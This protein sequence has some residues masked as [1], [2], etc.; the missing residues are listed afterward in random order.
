[1]FAKSLVKSSAWNLIGQGAPILFALIT[2]PLLLKTIGEARY[3]FLTV[4]WVLIG[5]LGL[6]DFGVGKAMT[7]VVAER[8]GQGDRSG[9]GVVAKAALMMMLGIGLVSATGF[10]VFAEFIVGAWP[11]RLR[12]TRRA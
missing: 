10:L 12:F 8:L 2:V 11:C 7:R 5:Y 4:V 1:M 3:G 9:A 6:F